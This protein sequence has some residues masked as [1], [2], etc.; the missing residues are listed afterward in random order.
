MNYELL[1]EDTTSRL[2]ELVSK[3]L[4]N[5]CE[6]YSNPFSIIIPEPEYQSSSILYLQAVIKKEY[7]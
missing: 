7:Q 3:K 4:K 2:S 1:L 5:G 6:L